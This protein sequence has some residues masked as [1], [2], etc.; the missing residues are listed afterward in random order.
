MKPED[1]VVAPVTEPEAVR[2]AHEL[3]GLEGEA[4]PLPGEYDANFHLTTGDG[5]GFVL[6]V[7][8]PARDR[9]LVE[10]QCAAL[11]HLAERAG[12]LALPRVRPTTSGDALTTASVG[13]GPRLVW[14][15]TFVPGTV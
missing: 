14:M 2:L 13:G 8:H 4:R 5:P 3:Y 9:G 1:R 7:M 11:G 6:K 12:H 10:L 15:L